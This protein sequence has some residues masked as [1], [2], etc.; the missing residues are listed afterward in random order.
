MLH[1]ALPPMDFGRIA[2][3]TAKQVIVQQIRD[4]ERARQFEEFKDRVGEIINGIVKRTEY[5]NIIVDLGRAEGIVRRDQ[6]I[7]R[8]AYR[9]G[10]RVR[11]YIY[12]VRSEEQRGPQIFISAAPSSAVHG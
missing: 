10:D 2:A 11:A 12:D 4:A 1:E 6:L 8:E 9:N 7:P 5:G 3:Q